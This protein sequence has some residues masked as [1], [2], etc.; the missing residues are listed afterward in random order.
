MTTSPIMDPRQSWA[1]EYYKNPKSE[2]FGNLKRSMMRAGFDE[3]YADRAGGSKKPAWL[4]Q[5]IVQDVARVQRAERVLDE[6]LNKVI[7]DKDPK[8]VEW[9]R[10][11]TEVAKFVVKNLARSKYKENDKDETPASIHVNITN[12]GDKQTTEVITP[13]QPT[14]NSSQANSE[15]IE[16]TSTIIDA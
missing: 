6:Y 14:A 5:A 13:A 12:Y 1:I 2:T 3:S 15:P 8:A 4:A 10:L 7:D 11:K 16:T 9:A